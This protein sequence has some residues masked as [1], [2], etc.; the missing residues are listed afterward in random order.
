MKK[1]AF[2]QFPF[3][4]LVSLSLSAFASP[5]KGGKILPLSSQVADE[6]KA[7]V[8][9]IHYSPTDLLQMN[10]IPEE[11]ITVLLY[12]S[13]GELLARRYIGQQDKSVQ[14]HIP[15]SRYPIGVYQISIEQAD[16]LFTYQLTTF[17]G[18]P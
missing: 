9:E 8:K 11:A 6:A 2:I 4:L 17:A 10:L 16:Q 18:Q 12:D 13:E 3:L 5:P 14:L 15:M 1:L 7:I